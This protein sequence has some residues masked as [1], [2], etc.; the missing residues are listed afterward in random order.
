MLL[1]KLLP[2]RLLLGFG[3]KSSTYRLLGE[4]S[5]PSKMEASSAY[6][7]GRCIS[8]ARRGKKT[9]PTTPAFALFPELLTDSTFIPGLSEALH[10]LASGRVSSGL[11][12][13][14]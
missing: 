8:N 12:A 4:T 9:L 2:M 10:E 1:L 14:L 3:M 6:A 7:E 5:A 11:A 13:L